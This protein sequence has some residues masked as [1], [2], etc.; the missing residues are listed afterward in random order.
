MKSPTYKQFAQAMAERKQIVYE[1][2]GFPREICVV[3]LGHAGGQEKA[4]TFQFGGQVNQ[5]C[6]QTGNGAACFLKKSETCICAKGR[7]VL[8]IDTPNR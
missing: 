2:E 6:R 4:A 7:G 5:D 8:A 1:Y 3:I